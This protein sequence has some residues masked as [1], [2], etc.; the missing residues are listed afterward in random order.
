[1]ITMKRRK[2]SKQ[3]RSENDS[4]SSI[5]YVH[6][7]CLD[8]RQP[9]SV[10]KKLDPGSVKLFENFLGKTNSILLRTVDLCLA[11]L[12]DFKYYFG[13]LVEEIFELGR[14]TKSRC[15]DT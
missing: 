1:M 6:S 4:K 12:S 15:F 13:F 14:T 11:M 10:F 5:F 8:T 3:L 9:G 7:V 2:Y